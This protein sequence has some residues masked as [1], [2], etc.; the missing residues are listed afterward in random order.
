M[1]AKR[2]SAKI[3]HLVSRWHMQPL[4]RRLSLI[5]TSSLADRAEHTHSLSVRHDPGCWKHW[6]GSSE[7]ILMG[8]ILLRASSGLLWESCRPVRCLPPGVRQQRGTL[9]FATRQS[10]FLGISL[11]R[12]GPKSFWLGSLRA[13]PTLP[14]APSPFTQLFQTSIPHAHTTCYLFC[15]SPTESTTCTNREAYNAQLD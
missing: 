13:E 7:N 1:R 10:S 14:S 4:P 2:A 8:W 3:A 6:E 12:D 5:Q 9:G 11:E 15:S